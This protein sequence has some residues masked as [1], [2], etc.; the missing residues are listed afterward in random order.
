MT[1]T[2]LPELEKELEKVSAQLELFRHN[3][4]DAQS[5]FTRLELIDTALRVRIAMLELK[6][7]ALEKETS[8]LKT[9]R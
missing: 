8:K 4:M 3:T 7:A 1:Q 6:V 2:T 9:F 5:A